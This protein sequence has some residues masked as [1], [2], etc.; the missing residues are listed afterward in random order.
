MADKKYQEWERYA[1]KQNHI[2]ILFTHLLVEV[3]DKG[4]GPIYS[5]KKKCN[6]LC[7]CSA[8]Y[9]CLNNNKKNEQKSKPK[10][11]IQESWKLCSFQYAFVSFTNFYFSHISFFSV[12]YEAAK[13]HTKLRLLHSREL[14]F[15]R[16]EKSQFLSLLLSSIF[17]VMCLSWLNLLPS[18]FTLAASLWAS[19]SMQKE[20]ITYFG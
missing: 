6:V 7:M 19:L 5:F 15:G 10:N 16:R 13:Q 9:T 18:I 12:H 2:L 8:I 3:D 17:R 4:K 11:S 14:L 20:K 1:E